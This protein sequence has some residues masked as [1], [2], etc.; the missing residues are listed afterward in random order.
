MTDF[1]LR[2]ILIG[3]FA[4]ALL[5]LWGLLLNRMAAIPMANWAMPGRWLVHLFRGKA[6]H[7]SIAAAEPVANERIIGWMFHYVTGYAFAAAL[8]LIWPGWAANPTLLPAL[9]VGWVTILCGWLIL[10]PGMGA[11]IAH[12]K[13]ADANLARLLNIVGHTVFGFG[14]WIGGVLVKGVF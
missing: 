9:I 10:A 8:M 14:L 11:G 4:T 1:I 3:G 12:A 13:R 2:S 5:D 7:D 6:V